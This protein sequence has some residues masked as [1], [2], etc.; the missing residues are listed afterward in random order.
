MGSEDLLE[1]AAWIQRLARTLARDEAA[2]DDLVQE[3]YAAALAHPPK[4]GKPLRPWLATILR[5]A[6]RKRIRTE[7]RRSQREQAANTERLAPSAEELVARAQLQRLLARLVLE[8]EEP[9]RE[10]VLLRYYEGHSSADIARQLGIP[11]GTVRTRL[12]HARDRLRARL[13]QETGSR[14][15]WQL[16]FAPFASPR[17]LPFWKGALAFVARAPWSVPLFIALGVVA[18]LVGL[19]F[20]SLLGGRPRVEDSP[21]RSRFG[22]K[23]ALPMGPPS[24]LPGW[25]GRKDLP[26]RR[27]AGRVT[28]AGQPVEGAT[29]HLDSEL[30]QFGPMDPPVL[31]TDAQGRFDFG[32]LRP[33]TYFVSASEGGRAPD[34]VSVDLT[35]PQLRP[36]PEQ[37]VLRLEKCDATVFGTVRDA[38]GG[39]VAGAR[40]KVFPGLAAAVL[41]DAKGAYRLCVPMGADHLIVSADGYGSVATALYAFGSVRRDIALLPEAIILG[42]VIRA[43]DG[44]PVAGARIFVG[45]MD[46]GQWLTEP[47]AT[48]ADAQGRFQVT[49]VMAGPHRIGVFAEDLVQVAPI[50]LTLDAGQ[51]SLELTLKVSPA[52][53]VRGIVVAR[54]TGQPVPNVVARA[55]SRSDPSGDMHRADGNGSFVLRLPRGSFDLG[56]DSFAVITPKTLAID[57]V[58]VLDLRVEVQPLTTIRGRVTRHGRPVPGAFVHIERLGARQIVRTDDDGRYEGSGLL[59]GPWTLWATSPR[60]D[61]W[62]VPPKPLVVRPHGIQDD[63]DIDLDFAAGISGTVV[64]EYDHPVPDVAVEYTLVGAMDWAIGWTNA[65]GAF[66]VTQLRGGGDY[67]PVIRRASLERAPFTPADGGPLFPVVH[68]ADGETKA[69]GVALRVRLGRLTIAGRVV[70]PSGA[71]IAD[72][73]VLAAR[74]TAGSAAQFHRD[75]EPETISGT[76]GTFALSD[77]MEGNY[78]LHVGTS[79]GGEAVVSDIPAGQQGLRVTIHPTGGVDGQVVGFTQTPQV[80]AMRLDRSEPTLPV[81][82]VVD[83]TSFRIRGLAAGRWRVTAFDDAEADAVALSV[84]EGSSVS[85]NLHGHGAASF[86]GRV[87]D[88]RNGRGVSGVLCHAGIVEGAEPWSQRL[89]TIEITDDEGNFTLDPV[90][91]GNVRINCRAAGQVSSDGYA[92][93]H[94]DAGQVGHAEIEVVVRQDDHP[95][96]SASTIDADFDDDPA[97]RAYNPASFDQLRVMSVIPAGAADKA[98]VRKGDVIV[99]C[100]GVSFAPL[101]SLGAIMFLLDRPPGS[102]ARL[103]IERAGEQRTVDVVVHAR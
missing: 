46:D 99:G 11:D 1:Q 71:P 89:P 96:A 87:V 32:L 51:T 50:N 33:S 62:G 97:T 14:R 20:S 17:R 78:A 47:R 85:T 2:A 77:L 4:P 57:D 21:R 101:T 31:R 64:D 66:R 22:S 13:D 10:T 83:G 58:A 8:L 45:A 29:V 65:D 36:P 59:A 90:P 40:V 39:V 84:T 7:T 12:K 34:Q 61:A 76:D 48:L 103:L 3:T 6:F 70:D 60:D 86:A 55:M 42:R 54:D 81:F 92:R 88:F 37:V 91:A 79:A 82:G 102:H 100:D 16:A 69:Q 19:R 75:L 28:F 93:V 95:S 35:D 38:G 24:A 30:T 80:A 25:F 67:R 49:G 74:Q 5:N 73:R 9:Y 56:V 41:S 44:S 63:F 53:K 94:L 18:V 27:I 26:L 43:D 98:G 68:L 52:T 72:A 15:R 23:Q